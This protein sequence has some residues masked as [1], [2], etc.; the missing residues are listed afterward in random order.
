ML[1]AGW[2]ENLNAWVENPPYTAS[3]PNA[4]RTT[5]DDIRAA[6]HERRADLR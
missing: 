4:S 1:A 3:T 5:H 6:R 2:G